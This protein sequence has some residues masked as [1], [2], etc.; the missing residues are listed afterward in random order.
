MRMHYGRYKKHYADCKTV[1][2]S[3]DKNTRT[4]EVIIPEERMKKSGVRGK[5]FYGFEFEFTNEKGTYK[6][7][8]KATC[9]ENAIKRLIKE[10]KP[11][12]FELLHRF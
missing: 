10:F 11:I 3:Y 7:S 1:A 6:V 2:G 4:I 8:Y 12:N 5:Q 9:K